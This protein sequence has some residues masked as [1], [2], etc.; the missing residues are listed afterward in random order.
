M[1][2]E[3]ELKVIVV[4]P[5]K[6]AYTATIKN[7]LSRLQGIVGGYIE[8]VPFTRED[9]VCIICNEEGKIN[10]LPLNRALYNEDEICD[11]T[12]GTFF[13]VGDDYE[14]GEFVSLTDEQEEKYLNQFLKPEVF[15]RINDEIVAVKV[16]ENFWEV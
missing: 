15:Y 14:N 3:K 9:K 7:E 13:I 8:V 5:K 10:G 4:E 6:E 1:K 2:K 11:I 12:A 16:E